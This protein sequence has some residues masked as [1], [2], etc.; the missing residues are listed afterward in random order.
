[1][2]RHALRA[3]APQGPVTL[4]PP[5][6]VELAGGKQHLLQLLGLA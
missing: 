3:R 4:V 6:H 1:M 2:G 5:S